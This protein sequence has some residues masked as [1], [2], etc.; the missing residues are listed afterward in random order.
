[1]ILNDEY[2]SIRDY[3]KP[4]EI[5]GKPRTFYDLK[6]AILCSV[7]EYCAYWIDEHKEMHTFI[8]GD[9]LKINIITNEGEYKYKQYE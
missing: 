4:N 2:N 9:L 1:M 3:Y 8:Q 5:E 7:I 6:S